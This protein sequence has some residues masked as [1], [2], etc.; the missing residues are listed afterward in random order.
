MR[1]QKTIEE[2]CC[3][4]DPVILLFGGSAEEAEATGTSKNW[5]DSIK[6]GVFFQIPGSNEEVYL[7][8]PGV[9]EEGSGAAEHRLLDG[10]RLARHVGDRNAGQVRFWGADLLLNPASTE[11][12]GKPDS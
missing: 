2:S 7:G 9:G 6:Y 1:A 11:F 5:S 10:H 4:V 12:I 3:R 8:A